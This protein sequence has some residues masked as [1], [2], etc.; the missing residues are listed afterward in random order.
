MTEISPDLF[1]DAALGYQKTAAIKAA[2]A[3]DL[4]TIVSLS[5]G[6]LEDVAERTGAA[7]RGVRI[8]CDYLTLHGFLERKDDHYQTTPSTETFLTTTSPAWLGG[9][10]DFLAAP[11]VM[12][13]WLADPVSY[14]RNG[15]S[16]GLAHLAPD[17]PIWVKFARAMAPMMSPVAE[18]LADEIAAWRSPP[19]RLLD[20]AAGHGLF[21][22]TLARMFPQLEVTA[23]DWDAV[24]AVA[25]QNA[26]EA[27]VAARYRT[28]A[29][30]AFDVE[31][32]WDFDVVLL[33]NFLH[34]FDKET[35]TG[36]LAKA[37][38]SLAA[39]GRVVAVDLVPDAERRSPPFAAAF[40]FMMLASTPAGDAYTALEFEDMGRSAGFTECVVRTLA[41]TPMSLVIFA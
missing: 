30:S 15:G 22:I 23:I 18:A 29:G 20:V 28:H 37:R 5:G 27:G 39:G 40:P 31:W 36:L 26:A 24:L 7:V 33:T 41:P 38:E 11:E 14:V 17:H 4:F 3:L 19:G 8:L 1:L 34:H 2:V 12:S 6:A 16:A 10:V 13:L 35:C 25:R 9:S 21:G 32:G